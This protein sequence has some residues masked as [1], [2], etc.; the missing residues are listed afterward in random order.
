MPNYAYI[1]HCGAKF[2]RF[3]KVADY[4][5]P[6]TCECGSAARRVISLPMIHVSPDICYDS[7]IDGRP[8]T[9]KQA[10]LQDLARSNCVPYDPDQKQ[11]YTRR[12]EAQEAALEKA[13]DHTVDAEIANMPA[14]KREKLE[15]ELQG[16]A[17]VDVVRVT[18]PS[19]PITKEIHHVR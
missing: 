10:R 4:Q 7:P 19:K 1:C 18:K 16:G 9:S 3:L 17:S 15:A 13:V 14:R 5:T 12:I 2:D 11:D 6:Q 8:I